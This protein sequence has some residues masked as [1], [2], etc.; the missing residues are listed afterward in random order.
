MAK[1]VV[2]CMLAL[3]L[4]IL[5]LA[6]QDM[7]LTGNVTSGTVVYNNPTM[8]WGY[9]FDHSIPIQGTVTVNSK[10]DA[11]GLS[12]VPYTADMAPPSVS[13]NGTTLRNSSW[14]HYTTS[15]AVETVKI[16]TVKIYTA[17]A[18]PIMM[19][20][21]QGVGDSSIT[22]KNV[23][24]G[25]FNTN[26][27]S[28]SFIFYAN[29]EHNS[30]LA[31]GLYELPITFRLRKEAFPANNAAPRTAPVSTLTLVLRFYVNT[32]VALFFTDGNTSAYNG[33]EITSLSFD[34]I[35][36][37]ISK[38]FTIHVQSNSDF[39]LSIKS[40]NK[41]KLRHSSYNQASD[42]DKPDLEIP[43]D[44]AI[45][46]GNVDLVN[47]GYKSDLTTKTVS[48]GSLGTVSRDFLATITINK[49]QPISYFA[50]GTYTDTLT[51]TVSS[52]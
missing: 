47:L 25:Q 7:W 3:G 9:W 27:Q 39:Y 13:Y 30:A 28:T 21:V 12:P 43:Y 31:A 20:D 37:M 14:T 15:G 1:K 40:A 32:A 23:E 11:T 4:S 34:E 33:Q 38:Q 35:T 41:G 45:N 18:N 29:I 46:G 50:A 8:F 24:Q 16:D 44:L 36:A 48:S 2:L 6:A 52:N 26:P 17:K 10:A 49:G 5:P 22:S 42:K 51:F 19:W